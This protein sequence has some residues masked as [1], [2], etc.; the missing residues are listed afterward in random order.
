MRPAAFLR[1]ASYGA[2]G[3]MRGLAELS[4]RS[5]GYVRPVVPLTGESD[6]TVH[7]C[8]EGVVLAHTYICT[9][10]MYRTPLTDQNI[11]SFGNLAT[12]Q[13]DAEA[14]AL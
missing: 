9:G 7:E 11:A 8:E 13:L 12:E 3:T 14:F 5:Y 4:L 6:D 10:I 2:S 1:D